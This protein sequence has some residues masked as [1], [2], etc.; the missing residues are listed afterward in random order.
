MQ[1]EQVRWTKAAGWAPQPPG[2]LGESARLVFLFADTPVL[3]Q[4]GYLADVKRAYPRAHLLGCSTAG[5]ICETRI[6]DDALVATAIAFD[7]SAVEGVRVPIGDAE[8]S[9]E[10]GARLAR[11]LPHGGLVHVVVLSDG[12]HVNGSELVRGLTEQLPPHVAVTG[13]LSGDGER[14]RET[15]VLW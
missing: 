13:G 10:A 15:L 3:R 2:G 5:T 4:Q 1:L 14:F 7:H 8:R 9:R 12:L 6:L 11:S